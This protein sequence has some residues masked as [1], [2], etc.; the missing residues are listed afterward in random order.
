M[1]I[2]LYHT[3]REMFFTTIYIHN[4]YLHILGDGNYT[5]KINCN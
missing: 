4:G 2:L 1:L 3:I 5:Q